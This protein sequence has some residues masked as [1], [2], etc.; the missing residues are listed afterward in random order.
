M[1]TR[2]RTIAAGLAFA[3]GVGVFGAAA[4]ED[5]G[6]YKVEDRRSG[7][8]FATPETRAMQEDEF[9][10]P[11]ML[12][13]ER[14]MELW[15][16]EDGT[17]GRSCASCHQDADESMKG[18]ATTYPVYAPELGKLINIEQRINQ[19]RTE[20]MGAEPWKWESD[21]LLAMTTF[22]RNQSHGMSLSPAI[23]GEAAPFFEKGKDFY[24]QR[25]GQ[26]DL[27]CMHCHQ[28]YAGG[29]LRANV[30][31]Q[32]QTNGFPTYRLKWQKVG[33]VHRR[34]RGCN[35]QVRAEKL[36]Y[37]ADDYVNLEL[38]TNWRGRG[39]PV[40]TPAVRN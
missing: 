2:T 38:Y 26:L 9:E 16:A 1:K 24:E 14:G 40:E 8:T 36:P 21:Q 18:V 22:V 37:G 29:Q 33:S 12:W 28:F 3:V 7:I 17:E 39:L 10:N 32:G 30:L 6:P 11:G 35:D 5:W 20:R 19:C 34:F 23:D 4:T 27:A 13:V 15:D 31:S 25:R